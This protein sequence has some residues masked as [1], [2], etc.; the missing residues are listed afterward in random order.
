MRSPSFDS[1]FQLGIDAGHLVHRVIAIKCGPNASIYLHASPS[2]SWSRPLADFRVI[3]LPPLRVYS[4]NSLNSYIFSEAVAVSSKMYI[5]V[6]RIASPIIRYGVWPATAQRNG[7]APFSAVRLFMFILMLHH[8][9]E[10]SFPDK[11]Y[12]A[13]GLS[14]LAT[15][16]TAC[17]SI[18][19]APRPHLDSESCRKLESPKL[20]KA[21]DA[22]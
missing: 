1:L 8:A 21:G 15:T 9:V 12:F 16:Y 20:L 13:S 4:L 10:P 18:L 17:A 14:Q 3:S 7:K 22:G 2:F 6:Q 11:S 5:C 19:L